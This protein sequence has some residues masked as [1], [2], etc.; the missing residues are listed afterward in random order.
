MK[1]TLAVAAA[2]LGTSRAIPTPAPADD[3]VRILPYNWQFEITDLKGPGC[4]ANDPSA[5]GWD[6]RPTFG[7]NTV[8]GS[9]IYYW[10]F[11]YPSMRANVTAKDPEAS[12]WCETT[13]RYTESNSD[14]KPAADYRLRLHKNGTEEIAVY[15][16]DE[17]VS[18]HWRF[19]YSVP[20]VEGKVVDT[21]DVAGP[22]DDKGREN[23]EQ[24][25]AGGSKQLALPA[26]G[27]GTIKLRTELTVKATKK[28]AEGYAASEQPKP[29]SY[30]GAQQGM[31]YDWEECKKP[32]TA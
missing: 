30:Y 19:E 14:K 15:K 25:K 7:S 21:L 26:C 31:S 29:G 3:P 1:T 8:D 11:A 5:N 32:A 2:L 24:A 27:S 18:A 13:L 28:G 4:P 6:T 9:E 16:L 12:I 20:G 10:F 22:R 17:G 23:N